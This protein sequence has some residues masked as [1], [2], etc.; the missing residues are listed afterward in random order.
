MTAIEEIPEYA[1]IKEIT[2]K[3]GC[4]RRNLLPILEAIQQKKK[5]ISYDAQQIVADLLGIHPVEVFGVVSFYHFLN[6]KPRGEVVIRLCK[7]VSCELAGKEEIK[8]LIEDELG[9]KAGEV[10]EDGKIFFEEINCFG[11]CDM[12][13]ALTVNDKVYTQVSK[14]NVKKI[15]QDISENLS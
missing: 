2:E 13:P 8:K 15:L 6:D 7:N 5:F 14:E 11:L 10:T 9:V 12:G 1:E 3:F 4:E